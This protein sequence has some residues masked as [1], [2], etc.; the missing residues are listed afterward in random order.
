MGRAGRDHVPLALADAARLA[1]LD[2]EVVDDVRDAQ[3]REMPR[4]VPAMLELM[5]RYGVD[6]A[7][8]PRR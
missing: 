4:D 8:A 5:R 3:L 6:P 1:A 2:V 7:G